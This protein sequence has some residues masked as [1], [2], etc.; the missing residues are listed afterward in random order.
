[1]PDIQAA[2]DYAYAQRSGRKVALW[3]LLG[4]VADTARRVHAHRSVCRRAVLR[5]WRDHAEGR[6]QA[7]GARCWPTLASVT[8]GFRSIAQALTAPSPG[9]EVHVYQA[10]TA[11]TATS[12]AATTRLPPHGPRPY[13]GVLRQVPGLIALA[14]P[15]T[16]RCVAVPS[17]HGGHCI[18]PGAPWHSAALQNSSEPFEICSAAFQKRL[19]Q[20]SV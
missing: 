5:W 15:A 12:A 13:A 4:W 6:P 17:K 10:T 3:A 18:Q 20:L 8:T 2:I 11:S 19:G 1:M 9:V 14:R 7:P 16:S